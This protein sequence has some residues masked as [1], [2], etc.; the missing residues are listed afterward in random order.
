MNAIT[1]TAIVEYKPTETAIAEIQ[2]FK[3]LVVD[4]KTP[5]G[6]AE[7]KAVLREVAAVR[8][9]LEKTRKTLKE[10]VLER[11]RQIDGQAKPLFARVAEIEDPIKAQI[12]AEDLRIER[13]RQA[14]I[15]AEQ[16]RLAD[17]ERKRK[18]AEEAEL[19]R[20]RADIACQQA[21]LDAERKAREEEERARRQALAAEEA[22]ARQRIEEQDRAA[23]LAREKG[24]R[25]AAE[26][27]R[28]LEDRL[29]EDRRKIEAA[30]DA[31]EARQR[32]IRR[33]EEDRLRK[34]QE[35]E[36]ERHREEQRKK[37]ELLDGHHMLEVWFGK[38]GH[39]QQ[40]KVVAAAI[41]VFLTKPAKAKKAA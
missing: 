20:Q 19:A 27:R 24:D 11:G 9:A 13:E 32:E 26:A 14:A 37:D 28:V 10:D 8:I 40:F 33:A 31:E 1:N 41:G 4:V 7:G 25:E 34:E 39:L 36:A 5:T 30:R 21:A 15:E 23:R 18:E 29:A 6:L 22:A 12:D 3:G 16:K 2:R 35:A 17:E 38:Y